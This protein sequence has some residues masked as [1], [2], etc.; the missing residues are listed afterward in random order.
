MILF[1]GYT[2][3]PAADTWEL[4]TDCRLVGPGHPGG[5][6]P[7]TCRTAPVLG[8]NFCVAFGNGPGAGLLL[9]GPAPCE[10]PI[11]TVDPPL[12]CSRGSVYPLP[13][14]VLTASGDPAEEITRLIRRCSADLI[15]MGLH[16]PAA[17]GPRMG[18]VT[19]RVLTRTQALVVAL[20]PRIAD[21]TARA[22]SLARAEEAAIGG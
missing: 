11:A 19:Y 10:T 8:G 2:F 14:A 4:V 21:R 20:P 5:G 3:S 16:A 18:S 12:F 1:G 13:V 9:L 17:A 22:F 15:V 6:Q 7:I